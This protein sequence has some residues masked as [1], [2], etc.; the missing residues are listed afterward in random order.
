M[1]G[2]S[3]L[4]A[5]KALPTEAKIAMSKVFYRFIKDYEAG[6]GDTGIA[7]WFERHSGDILSGCEKAEA[8]LHPFSGS[9]GRVA[10]D[11]YM[12]L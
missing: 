1:R 4:N 6:S 2:M 9:I 12:A 8:E 11:Y 7:A 3:R 5:L 10:C